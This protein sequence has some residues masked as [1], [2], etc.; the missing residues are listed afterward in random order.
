MEEFDWN[1]EF[2]NF[3]LFPQHINNNM[4]LI[5]HGTSSMYSDDIEANGFRVNHQ[6]FPIEG[7]HEII[8]LL[9]DLGEPS[10][11]NPEQFQYNL[12]HAGA[13]EHYLS[14]PHPIS[15]TIAGYPALKFASGQSKGGQIVG[16][17]R[18]SLNQI[19]VL[20]NQLPIE[21]ENRIDYTRRFEEIQHI[22]DECNAIS[23]GQ[24]II[25]VI[26]PSNEI[27]QNLYEDH[28]VIFSRV[29][30]PVENII[31]KITVNENYELDEDF[32]QQSERIINNHFITPNTIGF[33]LF[34][35]QIDHE[36][37]EDN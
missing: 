17:I 33:H 6:P 30:I 4:G 32:K 18:Q 11:F 10:D 9:A 35:R 21:N 22:S 31:A 16:K 29:P 14:S 26:S 8:N 23:E 2:V 3:E 15:F 37:N 7:L 34:K 20:I 28:R 25:Y 19:S 27:I 36:D 13:I 12:N 24:G 5:Y 1:P